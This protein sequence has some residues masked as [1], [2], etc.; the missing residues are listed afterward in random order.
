MR[1]KSVE[2]KN[3]KRFHH[4]RIDLP[5]TAKLVVL[6][7][8]NGCGKSSL[9]EAFNVWHR[10]C[11]NWGIGQND[12]YY[13]KTGV[14]GVPA[15]D[16]SNQVVIRM[17]GELPEHQSER[18]KLFY[19]RS[20]Y[21][22][23][24][25]FEMGNISKQQ[26]AVDQRRFE[27]MIDNDAAVSNNYQRLASQA[28]EDVFVNESENTTIGVFREKAIGDI[29]DSMKRIF[30]DLLLND[31]GNPLDAGTFRF[32]KGAS[33]QFRYLNLSGGE[34]AAFDLLLDFTVK[35]RAFD[36]TVYCIDEPE[37]HMGTRVQAALLEELVLNLPLSSQLWVSTHSVGMLRRA[38]DIE[39]AS[40]GT[41][42]FIDFSDLDFDHS[43]S[44]VPTQPTR[45]F[46]ER[47][48]NIA[49][50]D[51]SLLVAPSRVVICE[52]SPL[53]VSGK[54]S[55]FDATCYNAIFE[56]E[57]P[58]T[59]FLSAGNSLSVQGDRLA[60]I[61]GIR[62]LVSGCTLMRLIDQDDHSPAAVTQFE[63]DGIRVLSRRHIESYLYDDEILSALCAK[64]G[65]PQDIA[66]VLADKQ[67]AI[68]ES[69][70]RQNPADDVKSAAGV[71][72]TKMK[73]RLSLTGCGND[74][75]S[76]AR[77]T[78]VPLLTTN[79]SVYKDLR[80]AVFGQ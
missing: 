14:A 13:S 74:T 27:R 64:V 19:L 58:D 45:L 75:A 63:K 52:G 29:R 77:D 80:A 59:R 17:H 54:N 79:T 36:N 35:R 32:D 20:A 67:R 37:A 22:N 6:A 44:L 68:S 55:A 38:R 34:K 4:R 1:V 50:D 65:R 69:I 53:G 31:L 48:L 41:V 51:L 60:L 62:A 30:P 9:F 49:L 11:G 56:A 66:V 12:S 71:I 24:P 78:L 40:P 33:R 72:Y 28:L 10:Q 46:W 76:F 21:R 43:Q 8:P 61:A 5:E 18:R 25:Q 15:M 26:T 2:L 73:Q 42:A 70:Q 3:F 39:T 23:D 7:G 57:F 47:V 16:F